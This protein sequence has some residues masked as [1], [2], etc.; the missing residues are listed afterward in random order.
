[1][2]K[3]FNS[4]LLLN[5]MKTI[6]IFVYDPIVA[7]NFL[8]VITPMVKE[9]FNFGV[10]LYASYGTSSS[11]GIHEASELDVRTIKLLK[12]KYDKVTDIKVYGLMATSKDA[13]PLPEFHEEFA[14]LLKTQVEDLDLDGIA[15]D[16]EFGTDF[17]EKREDYTTFSLLVEQKLR[18]FDSDAASTHSQKQL[19]VDVGSYRNSGVNLANISDTKIKPVNMGLYT[20]NSSHYYKELRSMI[21]GNI[22]RLN[23]IPAVSF[24]KAGIDMGKRFMWL[25][26]Y[27]Y[28]QLA[29]FDPIGSN[30]TYARDV[31]KF[32]DTE[33]SSK[34][35]LPGLIGSGSGV[36]MCGV[37]AASFYFCNIS[38]VIQIYVISGLVGVSFVSLCY[39]CYNIKS[40][41]QWT[42]MIFMSTIFLCSSLWLAAIYY[43]TFCTGSIQELDCSSIDEATGF[44]Q[45]EFSNSENGDSFS[46]IS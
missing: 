41:L 31:A 9:R 39:F 3:L 33:E 11:L 44:D 34:Y 1:M 32:I 45:I 13:S 37:I 14:S 6:T 12:S 16:Y 8:S 29:I 23:Q 46:I 38:V 20:V 43:F 5:K 27:G 42:I 36:C 22:K 7:D 26:R 15:L 24:S 17:E 35:L 25:R 30:N 19:S 18:E 40:M 10:Y 28:N 2:E 4:M 21:W